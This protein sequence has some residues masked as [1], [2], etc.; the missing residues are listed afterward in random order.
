MTPLGAREAYAHWAPTYERETVVSRLEDLLVQE[1]GVIT[2]NRDLLDVGC[3]TGRRLR[4]VNAR[5][6][7]G[8]DLSP[9]MMHAGGVRAPLLAAD[10]RALPLRSE[11]FDV[12]WCR[13]VLGHLPSIGEA[14]GELAR[15]LRVGG[16]LVVSD[17]A[18]IA[19]A[20]GHRRSFR[21]SQGR[22]LEVEHFVHD[23]ELQRSTAEAHG[24]RLESYR[25][26][27]VDERVLPVYE[28]AGALELYRRQRGDEL[29]HAL[30][31]S[32]L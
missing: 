29:V 30:V 26:G 10:V 14:F 6:A 17:L 27:V 11:S 32:R 1:L 31:F 24:L 8:T 25:I 12:A 15:V 16:S 23:V 18:P 7:V 19:F 9:E 21:T 5:L 13:L 28:E 4:G 2:V 22:H 3:G 20:A